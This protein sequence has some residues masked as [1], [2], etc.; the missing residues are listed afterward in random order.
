[1]PSQVPKPENDRIRFT[2]RAEVPDVEAKLKH[3]YGRGIYTHDVSE[4]P[5][6]NLIINL[7]NVLPRNL[8]DSREQDDV[9][10]FIPIDR[11]YQLQAQ[12][13]NNGFV[14]ELPERESILEGFRERRQ[15]IIDQ[16]DLTMAQTIYEDIAGFG[17]VNNQLAPIRQILHWVRTRSPIHIQTIN[18]NQPSDQTLDYIRV[19]EELG[20]LHV[21]SDGMAHSGETLDSI[22]LNDVG[23]KEFNKTILGDVVRRGYDILRD[24]LE[25]Q[26]LSHYPMIA[27]AYYYDAIQKEDPNLWLD[28]D[29]MVESIHEQ[30]GN[31]YKPLY[32]EEKL[33]QLSHVNI[34]NK[35]GDFVQSKPSVYDEV[36]QSF[37]AFV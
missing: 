22:E 15:N 25:L 16:V 13:T 24:D 21:D 7:G 35:E 3:R 18:N 37:Q 33:A 11:V 20:Y 5:S 32:I 12:E 2:N 23:S 6:G 30:F 27:G 4:T 28:I 10:K 14:L 29:A 31:R 8:S 17:E 34:I 9:I 1:M 36:N 26:I 19:L